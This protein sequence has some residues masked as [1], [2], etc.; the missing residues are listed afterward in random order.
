M[1]D[2]AQL[3]LDLINA[4]GAAPSV[5]AIEEVRVAA[6]GKTATRRVVRFSAV[7]KIYES[8][9]GKLI[10]STNFQISTRDSNENI[11]SAK[12]GELSDALLLDITRFWHQW[13]RRKFVFVMFFL[14]VE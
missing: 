13:D 6:L 10:E 3:E 8:E 2:L 4:I 14:A 11:D 12:N 5:A 1:T 7:G 9:T